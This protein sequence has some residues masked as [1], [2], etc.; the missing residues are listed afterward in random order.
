MFITETMKNNSI[1]HIVNG[2]IV[3]GEPKRSELTTRP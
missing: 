2:K 3:L 1:I